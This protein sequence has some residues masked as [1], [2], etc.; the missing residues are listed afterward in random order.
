[1][2]RILFI[3]LFIAFFASVPAAAN[4]T[5]CCNGWDALFPPLSESDFDKFSEAARNNLDRDSVGVLNSWENPQSGNSGTVQFIL[6]YRSEGNECRKIWHVLMLSAEAEQVWE[7]NA[8]KTHDG[9]QLAQP[10]KHL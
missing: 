4:A 5:P 2:K 8:C 3:P 9:W 1:M 10:P 7:V 6:R